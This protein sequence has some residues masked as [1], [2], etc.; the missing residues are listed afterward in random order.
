MAFLRSI[1]SKLWTR[2]ERQPREIDAW[3][4]FNL[5]DETTYL[6]KRD[7]CNDHYQSKTGYC[8]PYATPCCMYSVNTFPTCMQGLGY[9]WCCNSNQTEEMCYIDIPSACDTANPVKCDDTRNGTAN[10]CCPRLTIC[11]TNYAMQG[12][13]S[14]R[15]E[16]EY[17]DLMLLS[18]A[19]SNSTVS[20]VS[21]VST[22]T[23]MVNSTESQHVG[24]AVP[25]GA[26]AG[27]TVGAAGSIILAALAFYILRRKWRKMQDSRNDSA[28]D[29]NN[30]GN[31]NIMD[32]G[33]PVSY[34]SGD[35]TEAQDHKHL[36]EIPTVEQP[37][38]LP[39]DRSPGE[40]Y[41]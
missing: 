4:D 13:G 12:Q 3:S 38:E 36:L 1:L 35:I 10:L 37:R 16:I 41:G 25:S 14:L 28:G 20:T 30:N 17:G 27:I 31:V 22:V 8:Y 11:N 7:W 18:G 15:C 39:H 29:D 6:Y 40:L 21:A 32:D 34:L 33:Q 5:I 2:I 24:Y 26:I 19:S 9:G 23:S